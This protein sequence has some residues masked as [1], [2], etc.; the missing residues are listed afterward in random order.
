M[1]YGEDFFML[2]KWKDQLIY[3]LFNW[4]FMENY[5]NFQ[6]LRKEFP[7]SMKDHRHKRDNR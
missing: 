2:K 1:L 5:N 3:Q 7:L 4:K 6:S